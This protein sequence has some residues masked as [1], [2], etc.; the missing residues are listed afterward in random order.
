MH[1]RWDQLN[2]IL[3]SAMELRP[4][5]QN[6]FVRGACAGDSALRAEVESLLAHQHAADTLL[7][8]PPAVN[9]FSLAPASMIG[10][11]VGAYRIVSEAGQGGMAIV[12]RAERADSEYRKR[13]AIKMVKPGH[14]REEIILRFRNERQTL[15]A[16]DHP[17]I[18]KLFDGGTTEE[19]WPYLVMDF[20]EGV[21]IDKYCDNRLLSIRKRVELFRN[22]CLAV[23]YAHRRQVIHRDLKPSNILIA[24]DGSPRLLD[25]GIAKLLNPEYRQDSFTT[26]TWL[27]MTPEF[28]SPEQIRNEPVTPASDIYSLGV[29]LYEILSGHRPYRATSSSWAE[30]QR[31][32]C[33]TDPPKPSAAITRP[34]DSE[35]GASELTD[36]L[37]RARGTTRD[38]LRRHLHGDLDA[39][40]MMALRKEPGRRY[41]SAA[42]FASDLGSYLE[43]LPVKAQLSTL[44]YRTNKF[45]RRHKEAAVTIALAIVLVL[46][47]SVWQGRRFRSRV[48]VPSPSAESVARR[49]SVA[50]LGFKNLANRPDTAWLSTALSE[51]LIT[52]LGAGENMRIVPGETVSRA[53]IDLGLPDENT[54]APETLKRIRSDLGSDFVV[55]GSFLDSANNEIRVD[56]RLQN[57]ESGENVAAISETGN[58]GKLSDLVASAATKIRARLGV[59]A[60]SQ[61]EATGIAASL[62]S[63]PAALKDYS[64]GLAKLR[65]FDALSARDM[66]LHA[67]REDPSFPL[68]HM[69]LA[70]AYQSLGYDSKAMEESKRALD[71]AEK[72]PRRDYLEVEAHYFE[73]GRNWDKAIETY[74]ALVNFFPDNLDY[75]LSLARTQTSAGRGKE[76]LA[77][78]DI[79]ESKNLGNRDDARID[80][81]RS[82]AASSFGDNR[83][84]RDAADSA[85]SKAVRQGARLLVARARSLECRALANLGENA[86]AAPVCEEARRIYAEAGDRGGLAR[87]LHHM[88]EVPLNQDDLPAAEKLYREA[89]V[90]TREIGDRQGIGRELGNLAL[91][92]K[93]RGDF[94]TALTMMQDALRSQTEAGDKNG[95]A[96]Q[97]G[98]IGDL[99]RQKGDL[100]G[101]LTYQRRSLALATEVGNRSTAAIAMQSIGENLILEGDLAAA[102]KNYEAASAAHRDLGEKFFYAGD[103]QAIAQVY[104]LQDN[105]EK[106]RNTYLQVLSTQEAIAERNGAAKTK[107]ALARLDFETGKLAEADSGVRSALVV[108][109]E[110]KEMDDEIAAR[111]LLSRI[112]AKGRRLPE[113]VAN[114]SVASQLADKSYNVMVRM[115]FSL[116]SAYVMAD[117][118]DLASAE[119]I[120]LE[121]ERQAKHCGALLVE[122]EASLAA[123]EFIVRGNRRIEGRARLNGVEQAATKA[124]LRLIARK[125]RELVQ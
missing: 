41:A 17:H 25:F 6:E 31:V 82:E 125:A 48:P 121:V 105:I 70:R 119:R 78:L 52:E 97:T 94:D 30:V 57:A 2:E 55:S 43:G 73:N 113:A 96:I 21:P 88:A 91:I 11:H 19:G 72:L 66:F 92:Y 23:D 26:R 46:S 39:I 71:L 84:R 58:A 120:T 38:D 34:A 13:V 87:T 111:G 54:F 1:K 62:P 22:V 81:A 86:A 95:M 122:L 12:Y 80:L 89:L 77:T 28:A 33:E 59:R 118:E 108:F 115:P 114:L 63:T 64:E 5:E 3:A 16:L 61:T 10:K 24:E 15:A 123:G 74:R 42:A 83:L 93:Y 56:L 68:A 35:A 98:N 117:D 110:L 32:V 49:P 116:D 4:E 14:H 53:K 51:M 9:L 27:P 69:A 124:R 40:V 18:V 50:I 90:L 79:L 75:G 109:Q 101:S 7:E 76:A 107:V 65:S 44:G 47:V 36:R 103:L 100:R 102:L 37:T 45:L 67:T 60:V 104:W 85:A 29:L 112:L 8:Q 99:L 106:A 20:V